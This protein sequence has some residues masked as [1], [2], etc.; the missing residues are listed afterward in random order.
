MILPCKLCLVIS[1]IIAHEGSMINES[2]YIKPRVLVPSVILGDPS[3]TIAQ[4]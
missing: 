4:R 3:V 2:Y 1:A